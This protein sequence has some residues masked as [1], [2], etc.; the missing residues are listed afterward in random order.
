[1][2][3]INLSDISLCYSYILKFKYFFIARYNLCTLLRF[4]EPRVF[5]TLVFLMLK[6]Y[7]HLDR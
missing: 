6:K 5:F 3:L 7:Q 2:F 4:C 1:M